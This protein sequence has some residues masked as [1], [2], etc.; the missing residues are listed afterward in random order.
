M[1]R[2]YIS[3]GS[4]FEKQIG[5]SR[6]IV[7]GRWVFVSGTTGYDYD[8]MT[9]QEN[10]EDQTVQCIRNINDALTKAGSSPVEIIRVRYIIPNANEFPQT[11]HLLRKWLMKARPV[12]TMVSAGLADTKMKIEIEVTARKR[13]KR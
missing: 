3:S 6:A 12:A 2:K 8:K 9:I 11:W 13:K 10:I 5:Y 1:K 7:D 4:E